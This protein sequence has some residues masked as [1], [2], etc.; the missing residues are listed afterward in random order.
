MPCTCWYD[1]PEESKKTIKNLCQT[2]VDEVKK[3]NI[4]ADAKGYEWNDVKKLLDH[5]YDPKVCDE[6]PKNKQD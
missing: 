4:P 5:L 1:P 6:N 3:I 2:L